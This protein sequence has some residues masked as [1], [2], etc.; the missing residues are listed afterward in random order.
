ME[1]KFSELQVKKKKKKKLLKPQLYLQWYC[2]MTFYVKNV[3]ARKYV[4][5]GHNWHESYKAHAKGRSE[6][7]ILNR[8]NRCGTL[9]KGK[10][11]QKRMK[12]SGFEVHIVGAACWID[13]KIKF[14]IPC[15]SKMTTNKTRKTKTKTK[16]LLYT[17]HCVVWNVLYDYHA[18]I[19][20]QRK[21]KNHSLYLCDSCAQF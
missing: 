19:S 11:T 3:N 2:Y 16:H 17:S 5:R 21:N 14:K 9:V 12:K 20:S 4:W 13:H 10:S 1:F 15:K 6:Q 18:H 7:Y 8:E